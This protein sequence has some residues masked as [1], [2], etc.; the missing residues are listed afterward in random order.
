MSS[1]QRFAFLRR[2]SARLALS[3]L[4][5]FAF[6]LVLRGGGLPIVPSAEALGHVRWWTVGA[7][8]LIL[9]AWSFVRALRTRHLLRPIAPV[10]IRQILAVSFIGFLAIFV[11]PFRLGEVVRPALFHNK[12]NVSF[13]AATGALGAERIIDGLILMVVLGI[14]LP[15]GRP[16][17]PLP[18]H[19][20]KLPIPVVAVPAAA[21]ST[22]LLFVCAFC[23]MALF[24]WR[25]QFAR[26]LT[27]RV[28]SVVSPK[29]GDFLARQVEKMSQGFGFLPSA[30]HFV[31]FI[32]E[33]LAY[34]TLAA[35]GMWILAWGCGLHGVTFAQACTFMG[36]LGLGIIVPGAPGYFGAFQA[37]VY[38]GLALYF[39]ESL[40]LGPGSAYVF[41]LYVLQLGM[42]FVHAVVGSIIDRDVASS[43]ARLQ[44]PSG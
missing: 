9:V 19:I 25:R 14:S 2:H 24:Y 7:Y 43:A 20:G 23:A 12:G 37:S 41:L 28:F 34:W 18:D 33:T 38:A 35:L 8:A 21:Y 3:V 11:L 36:V 15:L 32:L 31:P 42:M 5:A 40:V 6:W 30:R 29:L 39:H 13:A 16:L 44:T 1:A 27:A 26:R 17:S 22:L 4:V 10:P